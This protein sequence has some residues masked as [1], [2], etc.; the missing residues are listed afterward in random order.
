MNPAAQLQEI[1]EIR[2]K[3]WEEEKAAEL[4]KSLDQGQ[5]VTDA[6]GSAIQPAPPSALSNAA[7]TADR[8]RRLISPTSSDD[9]E[10]VGEKKSVPVKKAKVDIDDVVETKAVLRAPPMYSASSNSNSKS[11]AR[12]FPTPRLLLTR[13]PGRSHAS[14]SPT[15]INNT[16]TIQEIM[17]PDQGRALGIKKAWFYAF[18]IAQ[19]EFF[20]E[21][22]LGHAHGV[23]IYVGRDMRQDPIAHQV[24]AQLGIAFESAPLK[25][26]HYRSVASA[27]QTTYRN[28]LGNNYNAV[29]PPMADTGG[30]Y[31]GSNHSKFAFIQ[32]EGFLRVFITSSNFMSL[33][34]TYS[35][36]EWF[37]V[38]LP[39]LP[40]KR[41]KKDGPAPEFEQ[42]L[43]EHATLLGCPATLINEL[44]GRYDYSSIEDRKIRIVANIP[45]S[46]SG[47]QALMYGALRLREVVKPLVKGHRDVE[48]EICTAS[49]GG[50]QPEWLQSMY[51]AFTGGK[52]DSEAVDK[53][54]IPQLLR[55]T[56]PTRADVEASRTISQQGASQIGSHFKWNEADKRIKAMFHH[57]K[58]RDQEP[59]DPMEGETG[60][61]CLFHQKLYL[62]MPEGTKPT[63]KDVRPLWIYIG[64]ANF[65][66]AAWG[67]CFIDK[68]G[69]KSDAGRRRL[70]NGMNFEIG[71]V[72]PG[73]EIEG[74]LE[75]G[76]VWHDLVPHERNGKPF[77]G[78]D[79]PYNSEQWVM[80]KRD[81]RGPF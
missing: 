41:S 17:G 32:F 27:A 40:V 28:M 14:F 75:K 2:R 1:R 55:M 73:D 80:N 30:R 62:A 16:V 47:E 66:K 25:T 37:V 78:N 6:T 29:Y 11:T 15:N 70:A 42:E 24:A 81:D 18:F 21:L 3:K 39:L 46:H 52:Y 48:M 59:G 54:E 58:S 43:F 74:M 12:K 20:S 10:F 44:Y 9:I 34:F 64:S 31:A 19:Y 53:K 35:D 38:D 4:A 45:G 67:Q 13:T 57:Y 72:V 76:S 22:P 68:R 26:E 61:G 50:M 60:A 69:P 51:Y 63:D 36:N 33:D 8:K 23:E 49:I 71:V 79:K 77:T 65:S 5:S 7:F 56:F